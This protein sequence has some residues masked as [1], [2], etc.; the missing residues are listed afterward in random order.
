MSIQAAILEQQV[1]VKLQVG[2]YHTAYDLLRER[3][4]LDETEDIVLL[5]QAIGIAYERLG[6]FEDVINYANIV[7][8]QDG[9]NI[10]ARLQ[11]GWAYY[12]LGETNAALTDFQTVIDRVT[13]SE[14]LLYAR[15]GRGLCY[16]MLYRYEEAVDDL[17]DAVSHYEDW[18]IGL[19]HLGWSY[20]FLQQYA[21]ARTYFDKAIA[22]SQT[23][24]Y[25]AH[26]GR[27]LVCYELQEYDTAITDFTLSLSTEYKDWAQGYATRGWCYLDINFYQNQLTLALADFDKAIALAKAPYPYAYGGRGLVYYELENY[28]AAIADLDNVLV[29]DFHWVRGYGTRAWSKYYK[30]QTRREYE[31]ALA[32]F[33]SVSEFMADTDADFVVAGRGC[34]QFKLE[35]YEAA[36]ADLQIGVRHYQSWLLGY[37]FLADAYKAINDHEGAL[38]TYMKALDYVEDKVEIYREIALHYEQIGQYDEALKYY[39]KVA[40]DA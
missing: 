40:H 38:A 27:G 19:A 35:N 8:Q 23:P 1:K 3:I 36:I 39:E 33:N 34:T 18:P 13:Q 16:F 22:C 2:D 11:R 20:Y 15:S 37:L 21:Q 31:A 28:S 4:S 7:L 26:G 14:D 29:N 6:L 10:Y 25:F 5:E 17:V 24:Y 32:D 30:A 12:D 9:R